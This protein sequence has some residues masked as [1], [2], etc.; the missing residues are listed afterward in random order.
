[1]NGRS[2]IQ[3][4]ITFAVTAIIAAF[5]SVWALNVARDPKRWRLWW[6]DTLAVLD[7]ETPRERRRIQERQ[8]AAMCSVL[9]VLLLAVVGSCSFWCFDLIREG[10]RP[11]TRLEVEV[12]LNQQEIDAIMSKP[13]HR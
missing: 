9:F 5:L 6:M 12:D 8:M 11:K 4:E 1:M 13:M 7:V 2:R 10:H 3:M